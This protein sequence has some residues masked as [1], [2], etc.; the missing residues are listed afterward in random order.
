MSLTVVGSI[1][2]DA[3]KAPAVLSAIRSG[4]IKGLVTHVTLARAMLDAPRAAT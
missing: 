3:V 1:A 4:L 2:Y